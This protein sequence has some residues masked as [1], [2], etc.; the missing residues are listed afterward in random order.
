M[1][2]VM[3]RTLVPGQ[4]GAINRQSGIG[5]GKSIAELYPDEERPEFQPADPEQA[6]MLDRKKDEFRAQSLHAS[7]AL[8]GKISDITGLSLPDDQSEIVE[9]VAKLT[10]I[11]NQLKARLVVAHNNVREAHA[12]AEL[13]ADKAL[14]DAETKGI[15]PKLKADP[16]GQWLE[17]I[18]ND[19]ALSQAALKRL[20][21]LGDGWQA[22]LE[23]CG[24]IDGLEQWTL[25]YWR[26]DLSADEVTMKDVREHEQ[27]WNDLLP[28]LM[29]FWAEYEESTNGGVTPNEKRWVRR[30]LRNNM[31]KDR[32]ALPTIQELRLTT[33]SVGGGQVL[34]G[35]D[36]EYLTDLRQ[37]RKLADVGQAQAQRLRMGQPLQ[38]VAKAQ[39]KHK[40]TEEEKAA[41][42]Q[43]AAEYAARKMR[44]V[45]EK[46]SQDN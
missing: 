38:E 3:D 7:I 2:G 5:M 23:G 13:I 20:N 28:H 39:P 22:A 31:G 34:V 26:T 15:L 42:A 36:H 11:Y 8:V 44:A 6:R 24:F 32:I 29:A 9:R 45:E 40:R 19:T 17:D 46:K 12:K 27:V 33:Y 41:A 37:E 16:I 18:K 25:D 14:E 4:P 10:D 30:Q 43:A 21:R 35:E 1:A